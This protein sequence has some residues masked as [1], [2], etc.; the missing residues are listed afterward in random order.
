MKTLIIRC[1]NIY[2]FN[3][4]AAAAKILPLRYWRFV[5]DGKCIVWVFVFIKLSDA[6]FHAAAGKHFQSDKNSEFS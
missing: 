3:L 1:P 6:V 2:S 4:K 5:I